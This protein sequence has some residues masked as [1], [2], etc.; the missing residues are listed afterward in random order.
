MT[1][2]DVLTLFAATLALGGCQSPPDTSPS[3]GR[4]DPAPPPYNDPQISVVSPELRDWLGF[5]P[6]LVV[7]DGQRP[8]QV[9]VPVRNLTANLYLIDYR[10]LFYDADGREMAPLMGWRMQALE[11]KQ[12]VRLKAKALSTD[13]ETYRLEVKWSR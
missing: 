5:Q 10:F 2:R 1:I 4:G 3:A 13:A 8:M 6:A 7:Q 9:E 12:V 11:P